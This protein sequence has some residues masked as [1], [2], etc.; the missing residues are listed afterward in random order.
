MS[1]AFLIGSIL[2]TSANYICV[3]DSKGTVLTASEGFSRIVNGRGRETLTGLNLSS[4]VLDSTELK[5]FFSSILAKTDGS[6]LH[7]VHRN[8]QNPVSI[9]FSKSTVSSPEYGA[10]VYLS[11]LEVTELY[12]SGKALETKLREQ[13]NFLIRMGHELKTPLNT[14]LGYAQL[15]SGLENLPVAAQDYIATI[16]TQETNLLYLLNDVLEYSKYETGQTVAVL[17]E[18]SVR[19]LV[20]DVT[21]SFI[22]SF[23]RKMLSLTVEYKNDI[24]EA[25]LSDPGKIA[26]VLSNLLGNALKYTRKGGVTVTVSCDKL[27]TIDIEDTGVGIPDDEKDGLFEVFSKSGAGPEH[28]GNV[29]I[30]LAVAR[31]FARMLGGDVVLVRSSSGNGSLFRCTFEA[32]PAESS[33]KQTQQIIDYSSIKGISRPCKI[34]LVDDVDI[35]LAMLEIFLAPAGF[36]ISIASNGKE[37]VRIFNEFKPDIVFMDLIM[38]DMDGFEATRQIKSIDA[39]IPVIALTASIVDSVKSQALEAGVNDFMYK[40]FIPERFFEV[41]SEYTGIVYSMEQ[42]Q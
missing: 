22:D 5:E 36:D 17:S 12:E 23:S 14:V 27:I 8:G 4:A 34:L 24:P 2:D 33:K 40:P 16:Q 39:A 42:D 3:L 11:G 6:Y 1:D 37:A 41:I 29:G 30:G 18:T 26:Q 9:Q 31:I 19:K 38:P 21:R 25:I 15:L 20:E 28:H 7:T 10:C 35:N 32:N 13:T